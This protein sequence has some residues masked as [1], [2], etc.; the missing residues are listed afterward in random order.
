MKAMV[1]GAAGFLG[2]HLAR[3][4]LQRGD[5]VVMVD[6]FSR[7]AP[8]EAYRAL[9][10]HPRAVALRVDLTDPAAAAALPVDVDVL[11]HLAALN[12]TQ[13]FYEH[14]LAVLRNSTLPTFNL[15]ERFTGA[16]L[17]R[18]VYAGSSEAYAGTVTLFGWPVPTAEDVP[19]AIGDVRN[20]RWSYAASKLHGEVLTALGCG[21]LGLPFTI[22]R[23]HN[24]YGP[25]MG[26][27]HVLPDF[28]TRA[29]DGV[30]ALHGHEETR[31]F[32]YVDDAV[33]ATIAL[34]ECEAAAGEVVH[35][36]STREVAIADLAKLAMR[37]AGLRGQIALHPAPLG[38][39]RRRA[40]DIAKLRRLI[41]FTEKVSLEEGVARTAA[42]Y[43]GR[44]V[45]HPAPD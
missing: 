13:N 27:K 7:G 11:F 28:L 18:F 22:L 24:A 32:L 9:S 40:P 21:E 20:P 16:G 33:D 34:A 36:G 17:R 1:T 3:R 38:S 26:D 2:Y 37:V 45:A 23:Y 14:P 35:V 6:D 29:R 19:L 39:V 15:L 43:L 5:G 41:G 12:G 8:D 10:A 25:R 42:Y 30:F 31:S 44:E 4:L